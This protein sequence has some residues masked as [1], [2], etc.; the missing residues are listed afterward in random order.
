[1][2]HSNGL[3]NNLVELQVP[4]EGT[5]KLIFNPGILSQLS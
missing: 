2:T 1:M 5:V 3:S 4:E